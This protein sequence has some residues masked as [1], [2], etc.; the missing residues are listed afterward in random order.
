VIARIEPGTPGQ[1]IVRW[2][3]VGTTVFAVTAMA[4]TVFDQMREVAAVVALVLF[5]VG[6]VVFLLAFSIAVGRSRT[7]AIGIGGLYF[8]AGSAPPGVRLS[9][10]GSLAVEIGVG[11]TTASIRIFT[12]LA[13]GTL[14]PLYGLGMAGLWGAR[15]GRFDRREPEHD[16]TKRGSGTRSER[17]SRRGEEDGEEVAEQVAEEDVVMPPPDEGTAG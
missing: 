15:H 12:S 1:S 3:W 7:D 6:G 14:V 17:G 4:A 9:L 13:F 2:S 11:L 16:E 8:L 5:G 10:M